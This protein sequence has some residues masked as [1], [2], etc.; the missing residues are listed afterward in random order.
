MTQDVY[1]VRFIEHARYDIILGEDRLL[2]MAVTGNGTYSND[3]SAGTSGEI[4][5]ARKQFR[6]YVLECMSNQDE[7]H[8]VCF[9]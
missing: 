1:T 5:E 4:R 9:G 6:D 2:L 7:P 3:V 8:E